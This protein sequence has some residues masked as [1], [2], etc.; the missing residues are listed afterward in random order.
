MKEERGIRGE[1][2]GGGQW[3]GE[4]QEGQGRGITKH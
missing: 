3:E 4:A 2:E 1:M